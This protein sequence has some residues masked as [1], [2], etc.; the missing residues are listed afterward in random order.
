MT[1]T[2][3]S[4]PIILAS[5][6]I[7]YRLSTQSMFNIELSNIVTSATVIESSIHHLSPYTLGGYAAIFTLST[8]IAQKQLADNCYPMS[9]WSRIFS[10]SMGLGTFSFDCSKL[11]K[12]LTNL[13]FGIL[14]YLQWEVQFDAEEFNIWTTEIRYRAIEWLNNNENGCMALNKNFAVG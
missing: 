4:L 1:K 11:C 5:L 9:V 8:I 10:S 6:K 12:M 14:K 2:A 7:V 13:E 3:I